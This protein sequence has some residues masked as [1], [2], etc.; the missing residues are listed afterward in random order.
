MRD[1]LRA[2]S[3]AQRFA[4]VVRVLALHTM[5]AGYVTAQTAPSADSIHAHRAVLA[6]RVRDALGHPLRAAV[7]KADD[8][9]LTTI[10]DDSGVFRLPDVLP[11]ATQ[12][13]AMRIGYAP[14][15]FALAM[16]A[17]STVFIDIHLQPVAALATVRTTA[18]YANVRLDAAGFDARRRQGL[19]YFID[20]DAVAHKPLPY[21]AQYLI[22]IPGVMVRSLP[23]GA[24]YRVTFTLGHAC[25]PTVIVDGVRSNLSVDDAVTGS[26]LLAIEVYPS[27]STVPAQF[28]SAMADRPCGVVVLWTRKYAP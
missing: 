8:Q 11:G 15:T 19:G 27:A 23:R 5:L 26:N 10:V 12:F 13:T 18:S 6:G 1:H 24:G 2:M 3:T 17:D 21:V 28:Q 4:R 16:P 22:D 9:G 14:A 7:I 20:P 25:V